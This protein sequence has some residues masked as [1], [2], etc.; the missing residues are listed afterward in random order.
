M[1]ALR[2]ALAAA[3]LLAAL[4]A[5]AP[6]R[7][8]DVPGTCRLIEAAATAN[9]LP[10]GLLTRLIWI[11]SRF[12]SAVTSPAGAEGIA[13]FMPETAA[14]RGLA[15]PRDPTR[16][17]PE[18]ARLL[19]DLDRRF[20]NLGL[21][22]AAYNAGAARVAKWLATGGG[23]PLETRLYVRALT[24]REVEAWVGAHDAPPQ[25][26][27]CLAQ[28]AELDRH[29]RHSR[30][31]ERIWQV[32]LDHG[33]TRAIALLASL[34]APAGTM[35]PPVRG[36]ADPGAAALCDSIRALGATCAVYSR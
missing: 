16:A 34:P 24:G 29:E 26:A 14:A 27:S 1:T 10:V 13:Q 32:R 5:A 15:D 4:G 8:A 17:V 23:L 22:A 25:P 19:A 2:R 20:G 12:Q 31:R 11:E 33:L 9:H 7:A 6:S 3:A 28:I 35:G 36:G 18:A 30:P 21:A